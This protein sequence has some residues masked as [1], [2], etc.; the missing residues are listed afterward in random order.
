MNR[1]LF[2]DDPE[3]IRA[4]I[5]DGPAFSP[6]DKLLA[7]TLCELERM[8]QKDSAAYRGIAR[9]LEARYKTLLFESVV[10]TADA[11]DREDDC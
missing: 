11:M 4:R 10:H 9:T 3:Q 1:P 7:D 6:A 5:V 2:V 8:G